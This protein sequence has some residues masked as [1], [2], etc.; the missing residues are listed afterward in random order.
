MEFT[1]QIA[2]VRPNRRKQYARGLCRVGEDAG[3][4][5]RRG[6]ARG[7]TTICRP[8]RKNRNTETCKNVTSDIAMNTEGSDTANAARIAQ[9][10][11][12]EAQGEAAA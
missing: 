9:C 6:R 7:M 10:A 11:E 2:K 8:T 12:E 3:A 5:R 4:R 1:E